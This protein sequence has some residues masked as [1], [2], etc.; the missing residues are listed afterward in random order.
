[1]TIIHSNTLNKVRIYYFILIIKKGSGKA[2]PY[3][4]KETVNVQGIQEF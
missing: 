3:N 1:M 4:K 2:F